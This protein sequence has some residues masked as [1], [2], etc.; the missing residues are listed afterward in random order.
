MGKLGLSIDTPR[1]RLVAEDLALAQAAVQG[2]DAFAARL[3]ATVPAE[4]PPEL[5]AGA[6]GYWIPRLE[7]NPRLLGWTVWHI[8]RKEDRQLVGSAGF[9]GLPDAGRVDIGYEIMEPFRCRGYAT[10]AA[11]GLI[12]WAFAF[13]RVDRVVGETFPELIAS[14]RVMERLGFTRVGGVQPGHDGEEGVLQFLLS[15]QAFTAGSRLPT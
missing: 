9:K 11:K 7:E 12:R 5:M 8:I 3:Q 10:E 15:R 14:I 6:L 4:W 2:R 13:A 1:L